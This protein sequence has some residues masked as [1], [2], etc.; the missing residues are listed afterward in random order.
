MLDKRFVQTKTT[1]LH[2]T[3]LALKDWQAASLII[4]VKHTRLTFLSTAALIDLYNAAKIIEHQQIAGIFIEAGCALGGSTLVIAA[5]KSPR[6]PFYIYDTFEQIPP[7]SE[8][9]GPDA[10]RRY[11]EIITGQAKGPGNTLYYGYRG[12]LLPHVKTTFAAYGFTPIKDN[13]HFIKGLFQETMHVDK[14][15][16]L[17]HI[18][19]DWYDSVMTCLER[20]VPNLQ[21][22]GRLIIDDYESWSGCRRAVDEFFQERDGFEF[23][24]KARLHIRRV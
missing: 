8:K 19:G 3:K 9:D 22:G 2:L 1:L 23:Q 5:A 17:A 10:H 24:I 14:P 15:V 20:I 21:V 16:A 6:R 13:L 11:Q 18:D 12:D 7:P 4:R